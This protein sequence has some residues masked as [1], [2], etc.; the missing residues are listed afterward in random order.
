VRAVIIKSDS[1][2]IE[3]NT[4]PATGDQ[5]K[6]VAR[7]GGGDMSSANP[8][9][10]LW[11]S[12]LTGANSKLRSGRR[13]FGLLPAPNTPTAR[14]NMCLVP[15]DGLLAPVVRLIWHRVRWARSPLYCDVC[16]GVLKK[17]PGG[18]ELEVAVLFA[19]VRGSTTLATRMPPGE[20]SRL[21]QRF[22]TAA[23]RVLA[24][25]NAYIDKLIGDEVMAI[26]LPMLSGADVA[27][28]AILA[29]RE[30]LLATGHDG[31]P[32]LPVGVGV[33]AGIAFVG[34]VGTEGGVY[35]MTALGDSV[36]MA[37]RLAGAAGQGEIVM[38]EPTYRTANPDF[39][40]GAKTLT[41]KGF[42]N[43]VAARVHTVH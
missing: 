8:N 27:R 26:F 21:M 2:A 14:C 39:P 24:K 32:W 16:Q 19:D 25:H 1:N 5:C 34:S 3:A 20:Y 29:S 10:E 15:F 40:A 37:A 33:H 22:Y 12:L 36:N 4:W 42:D 43:P 11:R 30:L 35:E 18:V 38:S 9:E 7:Q 23:G 17:Y 28:D 41:L 6:L 13:F 31:E